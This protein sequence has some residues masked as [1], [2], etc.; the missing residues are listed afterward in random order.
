M[1]INNRINFLIAY[2]QRWNSERSEFGDIR[3]S[4]VE[5]HCDSVRRMIA[6]LSPSQIVIEGSLRAATI[7][8]ELED[9]NVA[10][11]C[12]MT[13]AASALPLLSDADLADRRAT[14][15]TAKD[16]FWANARLGD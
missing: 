1:T 7:G 16:G 8:R 4:A 15:G 11:F 6:D 9:L 5:Q 10:Q 12:G 3:A 14:R 2:T 13:G